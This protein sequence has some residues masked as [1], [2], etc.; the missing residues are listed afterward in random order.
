MGIPQFGRPDVGRDYP[1]R[2]AAF[3][4]VERDGKIALVRV[5][6]EDGGGRTDLPGGGVDPGETE[7]QAAIRECGEEAGLVIDI[8]A[9]VVRADHYFV[10]E[11]GVSRNTRG[12]FFAAR[13]VREAAPLKIEEDH[14]LYW[15]DPHEA[16][17]A[18]DRESHVWAL[19][20]WLRERRA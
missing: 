13:V 4:V 8:G 19:V 3:A 17:L 20:S 15:A 14:T 7:A 9:E 10:N 18:L 1:D 11:K 2:P 16:L 6:F 5:T 12:V